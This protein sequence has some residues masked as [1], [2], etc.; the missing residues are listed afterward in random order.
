MINLRTIA[1]L[2]PVGIGVVAIT[3]LHYAVS[4]F[5]TIALLAGAVTVGAAVIV[6]GRRGAKAEPSEPTATPEDIVAAWQ[7]PSLYRELPAATYVDP[8]A[9][10]ATVAE[11]LRQLRQQV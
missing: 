2:A 1:S 4:H 11:R 8:A 7:P 5:G 10:P 6:K 9:D 3:Q